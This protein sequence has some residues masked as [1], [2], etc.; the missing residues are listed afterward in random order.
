MLKDWIYIPARFG[1][2]W[3]CPGL[4]LDLSQEKSNGKSKSE[5][6]GSLHS[7]ALRSR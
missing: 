5:I 7:A 1:G 2:R 4:W 3:K 6:R